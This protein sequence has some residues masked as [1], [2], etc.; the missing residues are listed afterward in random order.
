MLE[1]AWMN[2]ARNIAMQRAALTVTAYSNWYGKV[3][4]HSAFTKVGRSKVYRAA[5]TATHLLAS[6]L[7]QRTKLYLTT[8]IHSVIH[9][10]F[11]FQITSQNDIYQLPSYLRPLWECSGLSTSPKQLAGSFVSQKC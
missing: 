4:C 1:T 7:Q 11:A 6:N 5:P 9:S 8:A 10:F 3:E 2:R